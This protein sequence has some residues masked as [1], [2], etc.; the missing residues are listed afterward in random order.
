MAK[1]DSKKAQAKKARADL[2][3]LPVDHGTSATRKR[4]RGDP[5]DEYA[6]GRRRAGDRLAGEKES[7]AREIRDVYTMITA[8][9]WARAVDMHGVRGRSEP[10]AEWLASA[11]R[12]RYKPWADEMGRERLPVVIDWLIEE[13][14]MLAIDRERRQRSGTTAGVIDAALLRYAE[15]S[16]RVGKVVR[17]A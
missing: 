11:H 6:A 9:L 1:K 4:L 8:G 5:V 14:P 3:A 7:A 16:G 15:I 10:A 12:D 13:K 2:P 17:A